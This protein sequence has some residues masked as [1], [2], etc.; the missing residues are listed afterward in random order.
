MQ[1]FALN[2]I[3]KDEHIGEFNYSLSANLSRKIENLSQAALVD[4]IEFDY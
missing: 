3:T 2:E 1:W 4:F